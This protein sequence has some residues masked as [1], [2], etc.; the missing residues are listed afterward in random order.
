LITEYGKAKRHSMGKT[1]E[2]Y[3][4]VFFLIFLVILVQI[5]QGNG[6]GSNWTA[7]KRATNAIGQEWQGGE[8]S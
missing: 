7:G 8:L 6:N 5:S 1:I 3:F 4:W 2:N